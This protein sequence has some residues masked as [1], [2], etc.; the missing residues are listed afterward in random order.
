MIIWIFF[1][2][3]FFLHDDLLLTHCPRLVV[4]LFFG[5]PLNQ[6]QLKIIQNILFAP[7]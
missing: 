1:L 4:I 3:E 5:S 6:I 7:S 2:K